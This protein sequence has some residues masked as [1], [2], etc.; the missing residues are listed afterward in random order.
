MTAQNNKMLISLIVDNSATMKGEKFHKLKAALNNFT[1][2]VENS[3]YSGILEYS[4]VGFESLRAKVYKD[5][6]EACAGL[7]NFIAGGIPMLAKT[8]N[9]A[10]SGLEARANVLQSKGIGLFKP[11]LVLL[12]DGKSFGDLNPVIE[13]LNTLKSNGK[14]TYFPFL[15]SDLDI[16]ESLTDLFKFMPPMSI[17]NYKY[18]DLF[19]WIFNTAKERIE[20]P[21]NQ[22]FSL[23]PKAFDGWVKR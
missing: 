8:F 18:D 9:F 6:T 19:K 3:G 2:E 12:T 11:W 13:K 7:S 10:L 1:N 15:L 23:D 17:I 4:V 5:F 22:G 21:I 20:T 14:L 16:D